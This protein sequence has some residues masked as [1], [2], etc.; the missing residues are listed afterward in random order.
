MTHVR[1]RE[2]TMGRNDHNA[3]VGFVGLGTM[4]REMALNLLKA[5]FAVCAYDVR[6]E[7]P[8]VRQTQRGT[9]TS[10]FRC[11]PTRRRSR[12]LS[13]AKAAC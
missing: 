4:G 11:S 9:R 13:M 12:R 8:K 5:G 10:S 7:A 1:T 2:D 3:T 6:K